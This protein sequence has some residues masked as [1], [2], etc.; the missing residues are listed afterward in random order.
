MYNLKLPETTEFNRMIP[1]KKFFVHTIT[2]PTLRDIYDEQIEKVIWCNKLSPDTINVSAN[3][4][5]MNRNLNF[6]LKEQ[7]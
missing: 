4:G 1:K 7:Q 3:G 2:A 5:L 6:R